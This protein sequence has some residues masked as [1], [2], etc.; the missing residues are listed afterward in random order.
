M[1]RNGALI[2]LLEL[3]CAI[4]GPDANAGALADTD[5][6]DHLAVAVGFPMEVRR[7]RAGD[8][9]NQSTISRSGSTGCAA[10][11]GP[12]RQ[13]LIVPSGSNSTAPAPACLA[14]RIVRATSAWVKR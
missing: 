2:G 1:A 13:I 6:P 9:W 3:R 7:A 8:A 4:C 5:I 11:S 12:S 10:F 14:A